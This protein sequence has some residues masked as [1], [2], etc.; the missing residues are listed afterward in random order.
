MILRR[1][2]PTWIGYVMDVNGKEKF[3][4]RVIVFNEYRSCEVGSGKNCVQR[5]CCARF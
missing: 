2:S 4:D 5:L 1:F 3:V